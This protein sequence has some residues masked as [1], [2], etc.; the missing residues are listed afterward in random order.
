[1]ERTAELS[2]T[3][4]AMLMTMAIITTT[5][6]IT[7]IITRM[8]ITIMTMGTGTPMGKRNPAS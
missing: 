4:T 3:R 8:A 1:M 6:A 2:L 5:I 7:T